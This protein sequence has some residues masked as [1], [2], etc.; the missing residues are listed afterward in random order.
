MRELF[1]KFRSYCQY[2]CFRV[3]RDSTAD[4]SGSQYSLYQPGLWRRFV[5]YGRCGGGAVFSQDCRPGG[6]VCGTDFH[7][8]RRDRLR[9]VP[10]Y[11]HIGRIPVRCIYFLR[12][13]HWSGD[14][15]ACVWS[16][17]FIPPWRWPECW[18]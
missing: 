2:H 3:V 15:P 6:A 5:D 13:D 12:R 1:E 8:V 17:L 18:A 16:I 9:Q 11:S 4:F 14:R 7:G 10:E